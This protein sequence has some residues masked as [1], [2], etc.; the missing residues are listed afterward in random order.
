MGEYQHIEIIRLRAASNANIQDAALWR[1]FSDMMEDNRVA[2]TRNADVWS[3]W[4]DG[5]LLTADRSYDLAMRTAYL[6]QLARKDLSIV[7][8][9]S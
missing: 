1:W 4:V 2:F 7:N 8:K 5:Q 9:G 6:L 3:V